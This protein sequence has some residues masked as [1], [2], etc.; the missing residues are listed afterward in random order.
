MA[1]TGDVVARAGRARGELAGPKVFF[2]VMGG[3]GD[4]PRS[5]TGLGT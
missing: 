4:A 5:R 2:F 1:E 3:S